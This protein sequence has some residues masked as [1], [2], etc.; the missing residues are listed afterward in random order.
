MVISITWF[1]IILQFNVNCALRYFGDWDVQMIK[2]G[3][4]RKK[5]NVILTTRENWGKHLN[6]F[7]WDDQMEGF[8]PEAVIKCSRSGCTEKFERKNLLNHIK[9]CL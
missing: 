8:C 4:L 9:V 5:C 7:Q 2:D 3:V 1:V 6:L